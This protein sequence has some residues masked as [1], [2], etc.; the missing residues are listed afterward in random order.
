MIFSKNSNKY[1]VLFR[2]IPSQVLAKL[3]VSVMSLSPIFASGTNDVITP[4]IVIINT[5]Q[6]P[7]KV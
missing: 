3:S 1:R 6:K 4:I 2:L 5:G 7:K